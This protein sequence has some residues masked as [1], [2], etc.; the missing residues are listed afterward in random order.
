MCVFVTLPFGIDARYLLAPVLVAVAAI[1]EAAG[2]FGAIIRSGLFSSL[3]EFF[4]EWI[5]YSLS[6]E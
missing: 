3:A 1:L 2:G 5:P 6:L 4:V